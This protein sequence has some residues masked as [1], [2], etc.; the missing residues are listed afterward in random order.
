MPG[1]YEYLLRLEE[2]TSPGTYLYIA[3]SHGRATATTDTPASITV[4]GGLQLITFSV[5]LFDGIDPWGAGGGVAGGAVPT[6]RGGVG[7]I[8][9]ADPDGDLDYLLGKVT[10]GGTLTILRGAVGAAFSTFTSVAKMTTAGLLYGNGVKELR[11]RDLGWFLDTP[12]HGNRYAGTGGSNGDASIEGVTRPYGIGPCFNVTGRMVN[13]T[14]RIIQLT[15]S[16]MWAVSAGR[17]NG[18]AWGFGADRANYAA[19]D[20]ATPAASVYDTCLAEGYVRLGSGTLGDFTFDF[21]GDCTGV[22]P[23]L[24]RGDIAKRIV[25]R[26]GT[27]LSTGQV[28]ATALS[29]LNTAQPDDTSFFWSGEVSK[30]A[31]LDEVMSGCCGWWYINPGGNLVLGALADPTGTALATYTWPDDFVGEPTALETFADPRYRTTLGFQR[32]YTIQPR[33]RLAGGV[34]DA[35][36]ELYGAESQWGSANNGTGQRTNWPTSTDVRR[37]AAF[38]AYSPA[39]DEATRQSLMFRGHPTDARVKER[40]QALIIEDPYT[41]LGWLGGVLDLA[42]FTKLGWSSPRKLRLVGVE[43]LSDTITKA[44]L[45]G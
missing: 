29:A 9:I 35:D 45:W 24:K 7:S 40:Y 23:Y 38:N 27:G 36:A 31:A 19:M 22:A 39:K 14:K 33:S 43:F 1:P 11:L 30:R 41:M 2:P 17:N 28:D 4:P 8:K 3:G 20:A 42:G 34:S 37:Q 26:A 32:N 13:A 25:T 10:S 15:D 44:T 18:V 5:S 12:L 6:G 21:T 16:A